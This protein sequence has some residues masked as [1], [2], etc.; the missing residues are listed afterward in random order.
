MST[1]SHFLLIDFFPILFFFFFFSK[2]CLLACFS[3]EQLTPTISRW[4][5]L[6]LS[7]LIVAVVAVAIAI[8]VQVWLVPLCRINW[9]SLVSAKP[10][11]RSLARKCQDD[12]QWST[13]LYYKNWWWWLH[14]ASWSYAKAHVLH[15]RQCNCQNRTHSIS[16]RCSLDP[17]CSRKM[18]LRSSESRRRRPVCL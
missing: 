9:C 14:E 17:G 1:Y 7:R 11:A 2:S 16:A 15:W 4:S 13:R 5:R 12:R 18:C 3:H 8:L 6:A 10:L